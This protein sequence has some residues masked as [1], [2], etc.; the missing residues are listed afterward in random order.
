MMKALPTIEPRWMHRVFARLI[1]RLPR[2]RRMGS[3]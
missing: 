2:N 1:L 3:P